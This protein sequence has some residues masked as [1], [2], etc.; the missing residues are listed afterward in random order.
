MDK[1]ELPFADKRVRR[2]LWMAVNNQEMLD[3]L[4]GGKAE[5]LPWPI[6]PVT[7]FIDMYTPLEE[8]PES[9][10]ELYEYH[11]DKARQ[12]LAEAGYA[13]GFKTEVIT[14]AGYVDE[15]SVIKAYWAKVGVDLDIQVREAAVYTAMAYRKTYN[16]CLARS[17]T[18]AMPLLLKNTQPGNILNRGNVDDPH[19]N[20]VRDKIYAVYWD[21]AERRQMMKEVVPYMLDQAY[22]LVYPAKHRYTF[23]QPWIKGYSGEDMVGWMNNSDFVNYIWLDQDLKEEMTGKR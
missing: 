13:D 5:L 4:Y 22:F 2:A 6:M 11:P 14:G 9:V 7:E 17:I 1:P 19:I 10:R 23:W 3:T 16:E 8:L 18:L 15:L 12:L 21:E 20:E